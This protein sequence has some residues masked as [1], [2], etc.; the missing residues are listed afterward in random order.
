[1][2][3]NVSNIEI[4]WYD[5]T[6]ASLIQ[7][8]RRDTGDSFSRGDL[9]H[10]S[11]GDAAKAGTCDVV[12]SADKSVFIGVSMVTID[13]A[14]DALSKVVIAMKAI[15][16][17]PLATGQTTIYFGE[18]AAYV[19]GANGTTWTFNNSVTNAIAHC[20]SESIVALGVGKFIIDPYS[21]RAVTLIG[22][23]EV[24]T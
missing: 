22:Y 4:A 6:P 3:V 10:D 16:K 7:L 15:L 13:G 18:A 19:T 14:L 12:A 17:V 8:S 1:M 5:P 24:V 11:L 23:F 21:V 9:V 2:A 20:M